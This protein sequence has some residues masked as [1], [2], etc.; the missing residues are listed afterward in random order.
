MNFSA[1]VLTLTLRLL[2]LER[3][4]ISGSKTSPRKLELL[5]L[6]PAGILVDVPFSTPLW[7]RRAA[8]RPT[9]SLPSALRSARTHGGT[10][11][12]CLQAASVR[13]TRAQHAAT[14]LTRSTGP[15][16]AMSRGA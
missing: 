11:H 13:A 4:I 12:C 14:A 10:T 2:R 9:A 7:V 3:F 15:A 8:G 5:R 6:L 1:V 16:T